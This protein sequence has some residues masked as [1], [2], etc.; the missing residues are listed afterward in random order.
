[1]IKNRLLSLYPW[2]QK[3][4]WTLSKFKTIPES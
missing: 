3:N 1:M 2:L 4:I